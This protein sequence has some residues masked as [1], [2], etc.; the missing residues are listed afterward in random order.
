MFTGSLQL[1]VGTD[2][3]QED[4]GGGCCDGPM[5]D[6]GGQNQDGG[7]IVGLDLLKAELTD[8]LMD[9]GWVEIK[10]KSQG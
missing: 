7:Q 9:Q 10:E 6:D 4:Q 8:L 5:G 3:E 2:R 1:H